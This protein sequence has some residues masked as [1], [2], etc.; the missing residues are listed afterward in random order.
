[1]DPRR[2]IYRHFSIGIFNE[3]K[4][5]I[6][7]FRTEEKR[8]VVLY[9]R[10]DPWGYLTFWEEMQITT[11]HS[12]PGIE[13]DLLFDIITSIVAH[14][15]GDTGKLM[16]TCNYNPRGW[17]NWGSLGAPN[18]VNDYYNYEFDDDLARFLA[19]QGVD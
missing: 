16:D 5:T 19:E 1:M 7:A 17:R 6:T 11:P 10:G 4:A 12:P 13:E 18:P 2:Y 14:C 9:V 8:W 3:R 15:Q